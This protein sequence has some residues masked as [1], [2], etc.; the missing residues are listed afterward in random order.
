MTDLATEKPMAWNEPGNDGNGNG[1]GNDPWGGGRKSGGDQ[2]PP[3]IDEV[4]KIV[5]KKFKLWWLEKN[6]R[7]IQ[8]RAHCF[9]Y[10]SACSNLGVYG[11][12]Y[13]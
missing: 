4:I 2:G 8:R 5:T 9:S 11:L 1:N 6:Q 3:D 10:S 12:L 13:S 7:W